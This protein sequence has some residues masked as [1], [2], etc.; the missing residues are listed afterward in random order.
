M[1][2]DYRY[3]PDPDL[4]PVVLTED[5]IE[6][7]RKEMPALP[8]NLYKKYTMELGLSSYDAGVITAGRDVAQYFEALI[9]ETSNYKS[10]AN[11]M[12]GAVR[13]YTNENSVLLKDFSITPS[14]L[15]ELIALIDNGKVSNSVAAQKIFPVLVNQPAKTALQVAEELNLIIDEGATDV[16]SFIRETLAKHPDKV[17]EYHNGKKGVLG[18]FMGEIMKLSKGKIDPKK[19]NELLISAL[20]SS[21]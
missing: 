6:R 4:P 11:W 14:K 7:I 1:A 18:L 2:N 13:S 16:G 8:T 21:K 10:A 20:E 3:F 9:K 19:T 5:Y 15:A 12:M 17:K